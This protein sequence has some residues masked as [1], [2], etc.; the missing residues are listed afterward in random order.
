MSRAPEWTATAALDYEYPLPGRG[1]V[2]WRVEYGY[3]SDFFFTAGNEPGFA[4]DGFG[5]LN[6][7]LKFEPATGKWYVFASGRN[8]ADQDY[9]NQIFLQ[10]SPGYPDTYEVG[11]GYSF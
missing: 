10:S 9:F 4:Q 8:L 3:R 1:S 6:A 7:F 2:S 11:V 5:L